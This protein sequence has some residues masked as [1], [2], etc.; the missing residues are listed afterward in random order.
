MRVYVIRHGES[1]YNIKNLRSGWD[2]VQLTEKG[3][4]DAE[5]AGKFLEGISF[6]KVYSSDLQR[7]INTMKTAINPDEYEI[8]DIL[9]ERNFGSLEGTRF[10]DS[11]DED[12]QYMRKFGYDKWGGETHAVF[13]ERV[14]SFITEK[15][16]TLDC[17][18]VAVFSHAGWLREMLGIVLDTDIS[19]RHICC[20]NCTISIYEYIDK[21][22][23]LHSWI[24]L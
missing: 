18:N 13:R 2:D 12:I 4:A 19:A 8:S 23:K 24:N 15:L 21:N 14:K 6:D 16:E 17:E 22:W 20:N 9:R 10:A 11:S 7:A 5:K 3:I 1:E